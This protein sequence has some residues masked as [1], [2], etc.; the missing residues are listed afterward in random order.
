MLQ[1]ARLSVR[2][3]AEA[4]PRLVDFLQGEIG[5]SGGARD[6]AGRGDLYYTAFALDGLVALQ[7]ELPKE[8]V[9]RFLADFGAGAELDLVHLACLVRCHTALG[10]VWPVADFPARIAQRLTGLRT[11]DGGYQ[12]EPGADAGALYAAFLALGMYGDLGMAEPE[13]ARLAASFETLRTADGGYANA[14]ALP[15]GTTPSTAALVSLR[16]ELGLA[17]EP[18]VARWLLAAASPAGGFLATPDAPVPD[19]LSTATALHA[20]TLLEAA[21]DPLR[22]RTLDFVDSLWTGRAFV[23]T[24]DDDQPDSEYVFYALLALGHLAA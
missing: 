22:E 19:L 13:P 20:L 24:W 2:P 21:L 10:G 16:R 8:R 7:S 9:A 6:R 17:P 18:E 14:A 12:L 15:L 23:G 4:A 1:V 11:A 5:A 3:L